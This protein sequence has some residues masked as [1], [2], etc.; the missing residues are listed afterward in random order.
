MEKQ[1]SFRLAKF[2]DSDAL[3]EIIE[4]IIRKGDTYVFDPQSS[5]EELLA[6]WMNETNTVYVA[7]YQGVVVG[8]F[9]LKSNQKGLGSHICN[10]SF[11]VNTAFSGKGI[12][13]A[14]GEFALKEA[15]QL[16]YYAMQF[17]MV[18]KSN[19]RAV[20][21]WESLGFEVIGEI[22][23]AFKHATLGFTN[24]LIMYKKL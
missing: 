8:T 13:R 7:E 2:S 20:K 3:W 16:G 10:A 24:A 11:M 21:L 9:I 1:I 23:E 22:P 12:G 5:R 19:T 4:P 18:I 17:N 14:M 15:K 6:Y